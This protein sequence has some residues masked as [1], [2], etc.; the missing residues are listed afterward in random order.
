M[1]EQLRLFNI[2]R[3]RI[4]NQRRQQQFLIKEQLAN[5][6][7]P[8]VSSGAAGDEGTPSYDIDAQAFFDATGITSTTQKNA[9][10]TLVT[11]LKTDNLWSNMI[12]IY[13][14]VGGTASTHKYN[15][16]DPQDTDAAFRLTFSGGW[17]HSANG[18]TPNGT[19][20][21]ADTHIILN[22]VISSVNEMSYGYYSRDTSDVASESYEMGSYQGGAISA[23]L[24]NFGG[25]LY[26]QINSG[27]YQTVSNS[28]TDG[29][30]VVNRSGASAVQAYRN[31]SSYH[32]ATRSAGDLSTLNFGIGG[33]IGIGAYGS[34]ESA[35]AFIYDGSLDEPENSNL[36]NAVQTFNT[37]L[38][39]QV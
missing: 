25:S 20:G 23:M 39:R 32:T 33:L 7:E 28:N 16:K 36:Y 9:V 14:F 35:F 30:F 12:G 38:G 1:N 10:N 37:S 17:T 26:Y 22:N 2:E 31:G 11:T 18:A 29:F 8:A 27:G 21:I 3:A 34:K 19:N 6:S 4:Y 15:L 24:I 13:P 5:Y